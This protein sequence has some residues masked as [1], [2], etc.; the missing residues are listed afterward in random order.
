MGSVN[1]PGQR[2]LGSSQASL[3]GLKFV[4]SH[5]LQFCY[6]NGNI[7]TVG[8]MKHHLGGIFFFSFFPSEGRTLVQEKKHGPHK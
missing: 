7:K 6:K 2:L 5:R 3:K 4:A 8:E 1:K